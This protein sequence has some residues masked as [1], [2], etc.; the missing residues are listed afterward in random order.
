MGRVISIVDPSDHRYDQIQRI[1]EDDPINPR[2][3]VK[4]KQRITNPIL[5][6]GF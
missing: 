3:G 1:S 2:T 4:E 6:V 5:G